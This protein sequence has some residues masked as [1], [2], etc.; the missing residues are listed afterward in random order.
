MLVEL[1]SLPRLVAKLPTAE[2][3]TGK[4]DHEPNPGGS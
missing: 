3:E 4:V 1:G 2:P